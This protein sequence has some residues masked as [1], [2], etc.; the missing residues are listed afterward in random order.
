[1]LTSINNMMTHYQNQFMDADVRIVFVAHGIRFL[2]DDDL[3]GYAVRGRLRSCKEERDT[4]R[5]RSA[6]PGISTHGVKPGAVRDH[7]ESQIGLAQDARVRR[8]S[9]SSPR[10][11]C[12]WLQLQNE[13]GL[14]LHQDRVIAA[15]ASNRKPCFRGVFLFNHEARE[16]TK[17]GRV[18]DGFTT[19][20][21][22]DT[23]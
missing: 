9:S 22:E 1:M 6:E 17:N 4:L 21:T 18:K 19:E 16:A 7:A 15:R 14:R 10:A 13:A 2:T 8:R 23:E 3:A 5:G 20:N 12:G 11:W